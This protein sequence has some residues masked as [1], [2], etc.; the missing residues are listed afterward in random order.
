MFP[1]A[2]TTRLPLVK[3]YERFMRQD[4]NL[5]AEEDAGLKTLREHPK[6]APDRNA[7]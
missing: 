1:R 5:K 6:V 3:D 4:R 7:M 2:G